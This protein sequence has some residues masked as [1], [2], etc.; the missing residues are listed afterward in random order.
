MD[1]N[2]LIK[3]KI[4]DIGDNKRKCAVLWIIVDVWDQKANKGLE[5]TWTKQLKELEKIKPKQK[6]PKT[7][8]TSQTYRAKP[9]KAPI[10]LGTRCEIAEKLT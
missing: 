3:L 4:K 6:I 5:F 2:R 1:N 9:N 7:N 10:I 8:N